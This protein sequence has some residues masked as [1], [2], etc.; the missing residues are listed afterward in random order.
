MY[1][2]YVHIYTYLP[3]QKIVMYIAAFKQS[4]DFMSI[5]QMFL[6]PGSPDILSDKH[7]EI[8][9]GHWNEKAIHWNPLVTQYDEWQTCAEYT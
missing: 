8:Q 5:S 4:D 9:I 7:Q 2:L 6:T 1:L 3:V